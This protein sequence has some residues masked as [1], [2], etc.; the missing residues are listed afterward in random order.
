M[1][2]GWWASPAPRSTG[3][4]PEPVGRGVLLFRLVLV[5]LLAAGLAAGVAAVPVYPCPIQ[6]ED[7]GA[8][9]EGVGYHDTTPGNSGG[10]YGTTT[11]ISGPRRRG[12]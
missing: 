8:G 2:S 12:S 6:V 7:Y 5:V 11:W 3:R 4:V 1:A 10:A 9:G